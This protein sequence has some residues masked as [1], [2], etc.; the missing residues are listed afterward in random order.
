[1][2]VGKAKEET[3]LLTLLQKS[4]DLLMSLVS[5]SLMCKSLI[6]GS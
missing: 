2:V 5:K 4:M 6:E 3:Y 1:M